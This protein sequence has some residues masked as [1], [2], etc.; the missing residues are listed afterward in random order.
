MIEI[1]KLALGTVQ[2]GLPYGISNQR[3]QVSR[4]EASQILA[5]AAENGIDTLDT[6]VAYGDSEACLGEIGTQRF[7]VVTKLPP[8]PAEIIDI[9]AWVEQQLRASLQRLN[10][11]SVY[12]LL[13]HCSDNLVG[14]RGLS[15]MHMLQDL[16]VEGMVQKIGVSIYSPRELDRLSQICSIDL[17]QAP[18]N[19][20]DHRLVT[21]GWLRRL[22]DQGIEV[23]ARSVFLQGLLLMS[24][25]AIPE[26]FNPWFYLFD[27]W[28]S[29]LQENHVSAA[30]ACLNFVASIT[31][32]DRVVVGVESRA[33]LQELICA[34]ARDPLPP[35]PE[36]FCEDERLINPSNWNLL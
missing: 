1:K 11:D 21:T 19:I 2:F 14:T 29:W 8:L 31:S 33:Q 23:H 27:H 28:H 10:V 9:G 15:M 5:G 24:R 35:L 12:G 26:K 13:L 16:K 6:A 25:K 22:H 17:V 32:V 7:K 36:L 20:I 34:L 30:E 3:G 4:T 18:L